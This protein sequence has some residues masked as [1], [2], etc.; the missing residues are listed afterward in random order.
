MGSTT[1]KPPFALFTL[2]FATLLTVA[3]VLAAIADDVD[4]S[5]PSR[6]RVEAPQVE[7]T[8]ALDQDH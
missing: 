3:T 1:D 5:A 8:A 6:D 7:H 2:A 4:A